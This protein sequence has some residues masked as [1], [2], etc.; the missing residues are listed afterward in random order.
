MKKSIIGASL[1]VAFGLMAGNA[2]AADNTG[3]IT[4]NGELTDTT[5]KVDIEG[6]GPDA[7]ITLPTVSTNVLQNAGEVT[8]RTAFNMNLSDCKIGVAGHSTVSAFF[9]TGATVDQATGRLKNMDVAATG[10]KQVQL[11]L[12]DGA[13]FSAIKVGNTSQVN[14]TTYYTIT[15]DKATL[16]YAVEYYA[17]GKTE[18]G[19]VTSSVVYTLQYK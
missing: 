16:P 1:A 8:G 5:C 18:A 14:N 2:M 9:E 3:T 10:A 4:F 15:N 6:Q 12:L 17:I 7:T 13:N 11:Q 19:K